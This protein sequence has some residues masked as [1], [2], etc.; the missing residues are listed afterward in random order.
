MT[1]LLLLGTGLGE[2]K[3]PGGAEDA[4]TGLMHRIQKGYHMRPVIRWLRT[5]T[6]PYRRSHP[7]VGSPDS[8]Y[9][10]PLRPNR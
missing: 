2:T 9:A 8:R 6:L 1:R 4:D 10:Y 3:R 7:R 5:Y